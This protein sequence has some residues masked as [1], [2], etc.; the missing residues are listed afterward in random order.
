MKKTIKTTY[1]PPAS[2]VLELK[3]QGIICASGLG[4]PTDYPGVPDPFGF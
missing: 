1:A 3:T 4:D 2:E